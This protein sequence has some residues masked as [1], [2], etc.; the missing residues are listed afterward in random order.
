MH[1]GNDRPAPASIVAAGL[2][3]RA[4][5]V[6][7]PYPGRVPDPAAP[8]ID[9]ADAV[10]AAV[11]GHPTVACL[12]GGP[13]GAIVSYLPVRRRVLGVQVAARSARVGVV[14]RPGVALPRLSEE[15]GALVRGVLGP[16]SV[17]ITFCDIAE[18]IPTGTGGAAAPDTQRA[19]DGDHA[20]LA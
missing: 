5:P 20:G 17:E 18:E 16:V 8:V 15:I 2:A 4:K 6:R 11:L 19:A 1:P 9:P 12:D 3:Y 14:V 7:P 13:F 10:A